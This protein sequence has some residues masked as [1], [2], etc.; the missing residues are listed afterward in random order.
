MKRYEI[1]F[2]TLTG[3]YGAVE[4]VERVLEQA[5]D[6]GV[7]IQRIAASRESIRLLIAAVL[8]VSTVYAGN[9]EVFFD[10]ALQLSYRDKY[11]GRTLP[12]EERAELA[13]SVLVLDDQPPGTPVAA[14][15]PTLLGTGKRK[16]RLQ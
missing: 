16:I 12:V 11:S 14:A 6:E 2:E 8:Q 3:K 7:E 15:E 10:P 4:E 1:R 13:D 5:W 9:R